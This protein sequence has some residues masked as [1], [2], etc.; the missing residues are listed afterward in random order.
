MDK[1]RTE[2]LV[3]VAMQ[4]RSAGHG[5]RQAIYQEAAQQLGITIKTLHSWLNQVAGGRNLRKQRSDAGKS[6][7][8]RNEL[9][10]ISAY[11]KN[12][13]RQTGKR[14][15]N[16]AQAVEELRANGKIQAG[17]IDKETGEIRFYS[18]SAIE[19]ALRANTLH[20]DQLGQD[21]PVRGLKSSYP[22]QCWQIDASVCVLYYLPRNKALQTMPAAE[23]N[24][25]KPGNLKRIEN[26]RVTRYAITDHASLITPYRD[27]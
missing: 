16:V 19:R 17:Y 25:N 9:M 24:K 8:D 21:S 1:T 7:I 15:R 11:M 27:S 23:F 14:L 22:N 13:M 4:A 10:I 18:T 26:D 6:G 2:Y 20:P 12:S 3:Q 5:Q